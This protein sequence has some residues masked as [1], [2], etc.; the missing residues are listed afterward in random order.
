MADFTVETRIS[1][2]VAEVFAANRDE[3]PRLATYIPNVRSVEVT[4]RVEEGPLVRLVNQW[5]ASADVPKALKGFITE[6]KLGWIDRATWDADRRQCSWSLEITAFKDAVTCRGETRFT[7]EGQHTRMIIA[8]NLQVDA[9][10]AGIP[11]PKMLAGGIGRAIETFA[12]A[13]IKPNQEAMGRA[14]EK[15]LNEKHKGDA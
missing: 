12:V 7:D 13:L 1:H 5:R 14:V 9:T 15:Y 11:I 2:P 8:G 4:E 3:L 10:R 6:E